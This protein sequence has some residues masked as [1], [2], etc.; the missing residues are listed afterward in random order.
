ML[1]SWIISM[2][3]LP[4]SYAWTKGWAKVRYNQTTAFGL[5]KS[6]LESTMINLE[7]MVHISLSEALDIGCIQM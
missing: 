2:T 3:S 6:D 7:H 1:I 5:I 4:L